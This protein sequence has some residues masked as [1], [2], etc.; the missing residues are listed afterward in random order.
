MEDKLDA[1]GF[2]VELPD[3]KGTTMIKGKEALVD[4]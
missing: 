4:V 3:G 1:Q 2:E